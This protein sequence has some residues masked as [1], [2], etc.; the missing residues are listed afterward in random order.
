M[1]VHDFGWFNA[2]LFLVGGNMLVAQLGCLVLFFAGPDNNVE[3]DGCSHVDWQDRRPL[4]PMNGEAFAVYFQA[5][6]FDITAARVHVDDGVEQWID[7]VF[8]H[9]RGP[10]AV[11]RAAMPATAAQTLR[12]YIELTDGS[13]TDY[14]SVG[15]MSDNAPTDGGWVIDRITLSHAPLGATLVNPGGVVFKVWAPSASSAWVRGEFNGWA[16]GNPMSRHGEHFVAYVPTASDRQMYKY[17]FE[18]GAIWK[19][20]PRGR[21][22]NPG[23]NYNAHVENPFRYAWQTTGFQTPAFED[24]IIYELH[25]GTFSGRNDPVASG[26]IPASYR[27][28]AAH[29]D[30]LADLGVNVVHLMPVTEYPWDFSAGYNPLTMW[31]PEWKHGAPDD[32]KYL[33]DTL[34]GAGIAVIAD[35]CWNHVSPTD[36]FLWH[37]DSHAAQIY[38][39]VPD[40]QTPWGSQADFQR[41]E[42]RAYYAHSTLKWLEEYRL[43]GFRMD[44]TDFMN[45]PPQEAEGWSLMQWHNNLIDNR[46]VDK[47]SIAEQ[48]PDDEF[49]TRPT[50]QGGAGFDSQWHDAYKYAIRNAVLAAGLGD[51]DMSALAAAI[52]GGGPNLRGTKVVNYLELHDECTTANGGRIVRAIDPS[53]PHNDVYAKGRYKLAQGLT[54]LAPGIPAIHQGSEW[55]EDTDF[56]AGSPSGENR[57]NWDLRSANVGIVRFFKDVIAVRRTNGAFRASAGYQVYHVNDAINLLALQRYDAGGN[58]CVVVANFN[59]SDL[60]N[61]RLGFPQPGEWTELLNSQSALYDGNNVGNG[62]SITTDETDYDGYQQS[63]VITV[64]Q[65]GLLVFRHRETAPPCPADL[66]GDHSV[67]LNDLTILLSHFGTAA[68]ASHEDGD[69]DGNGTVDLNDLTALLS[70]FG[71]ACP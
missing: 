54:I 45:L 56:G 39:R 27:D 28:A 53:W 21:S 52:N 51:P 7:A 44:A 31:A 62:G 17:Y 40:V 69:L 61:Y 3:W 8:D 41:G 14:L 23:D 48:L 2:P 18:P 35:V 29:V 66:D 70:A 9:D 67:S 59:N 34:H 4:C 42:V 30:H 26:A 68:G 32:L 65:M 49:I 57:I 6:R 37:F 50:S 22:L 12:Y 1:P 43:D 38:F 24:M 47:I 5:Y 15:G 60:Y 11:W 13:D 63:A 46:W 71:T 20:D 16:L 64:P 25:V 33:I 19:P 10:Y 55:L 58:V 36:N